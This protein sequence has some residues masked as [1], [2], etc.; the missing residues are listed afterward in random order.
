[1]G[2]CGRRRTARDDVGDKVGEFSQSLLFFFLPSPLP[3]P[4]VDRK[5]SEAEAGHVRW[6]KKSWQSE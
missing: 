2:E 6:S 1:V 5:R 4:F 3:L